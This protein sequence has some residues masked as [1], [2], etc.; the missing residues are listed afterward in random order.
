MQLAAQQ[1][2]AQRMMQ[3]QMLASGQ[4]RPMLPAQVLALQQAQMQQRMAAAAGAAA[5]AP[6]KGSTRKRGKAAAAAP[7][8]AAMFAATHTAT[9]RSADPF[10]DPG[11]ARR[12][13]VALARWPVHGVFAWWHHVQLTHRMAPL[14]P[15]CRQAGVG[16]G[17][18]IPVVAR[19]DTGPSARPVVPA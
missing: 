7:A 11:G 12:R 2:V 18:D 10:A 16:Q 13:G 6:K 4:M 9:P 14:A 17:R 19:Q 1:L 5:A 15:P 3:Q 8:P